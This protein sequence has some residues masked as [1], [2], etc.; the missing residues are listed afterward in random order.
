MARIMPISATWLNSI[1]V[2]GGKV[3]RVIGGWSGLVGGEDAAHSAATSSENAAS[4]L[5]VARKSR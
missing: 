3:N 2:L 5:L 1:R 4:Q